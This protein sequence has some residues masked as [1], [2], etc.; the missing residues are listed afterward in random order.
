METTQEKEYLGRYISQ[1]YRNAHYIIGHKFLESGISSSKIMFLQELYK[2]DGINQEKLSKRL[3]VD[4]ATTA[5]AIKKLEEK[6]YVVRQKD[7]LD[8]RSYKVYISQKSKDTKEE[9]DKAIEEWENEIFQGITE[10]EK[11]MLMSVLKKICLNDRK[12]R[13]YDK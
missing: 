11:E 7:E 6:G 1:I 5:R 4:K 3:C 12:E 10:E 9:I 2:E 13:E 8:N